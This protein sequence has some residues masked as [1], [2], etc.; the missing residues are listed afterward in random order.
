MGKGALLS[1]SAL[2]A[3]QA[4]LFVCF[5]NPSKI[6]II[7]IITAVVVTCFKS[8]KYSYKTKPFWPVAVLP[9]LPQCVLPACSNS[10]LCVK[11]GGA[12][13]ARA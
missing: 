1:A 3:Y 12:R 10:L 8:K 13:L 5:V 4:V 7:V 9:S 6:I 2:A 11:Q